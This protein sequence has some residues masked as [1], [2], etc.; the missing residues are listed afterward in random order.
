M[1]DPVSLAVSLGSLG[2]A[3]WAALGSHRARKWQVEQDLQRQAT[4]V[5]IEFGHASEDRE[6]YVFSLNDT[7]PRPEPRYYELTVHVVNDGDAAEHLTQ[8]YVE[9]PGPEDGRHGLE[10]VDRRS[11]IEIP[12]RGR[13]SESINA[14]KLEWD[15]AREGVIAYAHLA[16]GDIIESEVEHL[17]EFIL[18]SIADH[19]RGA[20]P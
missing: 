10:I 13:H 3:G 12:A 15:V 2:V 5:R 1:A 18:D 9:Q 14:T 20:R 17:H 4:R 11:H 8:L 6:V 19:N 7:D 16:R